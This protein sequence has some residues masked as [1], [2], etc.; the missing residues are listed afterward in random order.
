MR[1]LMGI[2]AEEP[3]ALTSRLIFYSGGDSFL[4]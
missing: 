4:K 2:V 1:Q 3:A